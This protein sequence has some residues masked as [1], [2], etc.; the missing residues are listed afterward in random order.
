[1]DNPIDRETMSDSPITSR[2]KF[3]GTTAGIASAGLAGCSDSSEGDTGAETGGGSATPTAGGTTSSSDDLADSLTVATFGG[4]YGEALKTAYFDTFEEEYGVTINQQTADIGN[5]ITQMQAGTATGVHWLDVVWSSFYNAYQ[6]DIWQPFRE[7]NLPAIDRLRSEFRPENFPY[8]PGDQYWMIPVEVSTV[9]AC[10]N[11]DEMSEPTTWDDMYNE[12][13][14]G[15]LGF[16]G[17]I[18]LVVGIAALHNEIDLNNL[19]EDYESKMQQV[20]ETVQMQ[21]E[22]VLQWYD[23]PTTMNQL[24]TSGEVIGGTHLDARVNG[25]RASEDIPVQFKIPEGGSTMSGTGGA[26]PQTVDDPHRKTAELLSNWTLKEEPS[27]RFAE[28]YSYV[29]PINFDQLPEL[30]EDHAVYNNFDRLVMWDPDIINSHREE[31]QLR[32]QE[33]IG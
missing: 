29:Q 25:L 17:T 23:S 27:H 13:T 3:L 9:A 5:L 19:E 8:M 7:E 33:I 28:E 2:R 30:Y 6:D 15:S 26:I 32:F 24:L 1:M 10:Y 11:S 16:Y 22:Y 20:W 31:W 21:N 18:D 14:Q 4:S 12:T